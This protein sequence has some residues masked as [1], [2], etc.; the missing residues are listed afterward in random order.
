MAAGK[1]PGRRGC[2]RSISVAVRA[3]RANRDVGG[4]ERGL[5][6]VAVERRRGRHASGLAAPASSAATRDEQPEAQRVV[7]PV[8]AGDRV[9]IRTAVA[10]V[11]GGAIDEA[12]PARRSAAAPRAA[13][14]RGS[15]WLRQRDGRVVRRSSRPRA[16]AGTRAA[17]RACRARA[18]SSAAG[19]AATHIAEPAGL[20]P[21]RALGGGEENSKSFVCHRPGSIAAMSRRSIPMRRH[22]RHQDAARARPRSLAAGVVIVFERRYADAR[23]RSSPTLCALSSTRRGGARRRDRR[24]VLRRRRSDGRPA[25]CGHEFPMAARAPMR[26]RGRRRSGRACQRFPRRGGRHRRIAAGSARHDP[27][28]RVDVA[29][30]ATRD[31]CGHRARG[32][33]PRV[34]RRSIC[35]RSAGEGGHVGF[36]PRTSARPACGG[37]SGARSGECASSTSF[38][39][40]GSRG[41]MISCGGRP[42]R[43]APTR[44]GAAFDPPTRAREALD[45]FVACYGAAAGDYALAILARG[46]VCSPA[47]S[48]PRSCRGCAMGRSSSI[49]RQGRARADWRRGSRSRG[50]RGEARAARR[51]ATGARGGRSL[52]PRNAPCAE[53]TD[54]IRSGWAPR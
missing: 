18:A 50:R 25:G 40:R 8:G 27:G 12:T 20:H 21:R 29:R 24:R 38:R 17:A 35:R 4:R 2:G 46:G 44:Y 45:L 6:V 32:C 26:W 48:R 49:Q 1:T 41:S 52:T 31:R 5:P 39:A 51:G 19:S 34:E 22:R 3:A 42:P 15:A 13:A 9:L 36:A 37:M 11:K 16:P 30:A 33:L 10:I 54:A 23:S 53:A 7:R 14:R 43:I 28:R 47:A